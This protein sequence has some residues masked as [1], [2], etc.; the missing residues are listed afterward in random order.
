[1]STETDLLAPLVKTAVIPG[2]P[3][4]AFDLFTRRMDEWWPRRTHS[5]GQDDAVSV[6]MQ[7]RIGGQIVETGVGGAVDVWGTVTAWMPGERV[8]FTW[9]PGQP[10]SEAT[11]V[12][13]TFE[14]VNDGTR[15][16]LVHSGWRNRPD[17]T[18]ARH[19]YDAGWDVVLGHYIEAGSDR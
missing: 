18:E 12:A 14:P 19:G 10:P 3:A 15:V 13:V 7:C 6:E 4:R 2:T 16:T 5:V 9:H 11:E 1:M 8:A 17:G